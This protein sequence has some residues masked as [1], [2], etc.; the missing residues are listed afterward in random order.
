MGG[1]EVREVRGVGDVGAILPPAPTR[2]QL[3]F[4]PSAILSPSPPLL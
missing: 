3:R 1:R 4:F 2:A